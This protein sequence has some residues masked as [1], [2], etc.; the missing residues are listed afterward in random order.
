MATNQ[1]QLVARSNCAAGTTFY[2]CKSNS[3]S[4]CCSVDPCDL[5]SCPDATTAGS[6]TRPS[7]TF[8]VT[9]NTASPSAGSFD[10]TATETISSSSSTFSALPPTSVL[11]AASSSTLVTIIVSPSDSASSPTGGA[12]LPSYHENRNP[13]TIAVTASVAGLVVFASVAFCFVLSRHHRRARLRALVAQGHAGDEPTDKHSDAGGKENGG[14]I[15]S[16]FGGK[17]LRHQMA[18]FFTFKKADN[19]H[20]HDHPA[21]LVSGSQHRAHSGFWSPE[22]FKNEDTPNLDSKAIAPPAELHDSSLA[23]GQPAANELSA[24]AEVL[25]D[26]RPTTSAGAGKKTVNRDSVM[27]LWPTFQATSPADSSSMMGDGL[28]SLTPRT[29][30]PSPG[31]SWAEYKYMAEL[32]EDGC[33]DDEER[34]WIQKCC[35]ATPKDDDRSQQ[36][37]P[38]GGLMIELDPAKNDG[39]GHTETNTDAQ[40]DQPVGGL[41]LEHEPT[42]EKDD[43]HAKVNV[44]AHLGQQVSPVLDGDNFQDG[45]GGDGNISPRIAPTEE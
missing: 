10:L 26:S 30:K 45:T 11:T 12:A 29:P 37:Q 28:A 4:G 24:E 39:D 8:V 5:S 6:S 40:Q 23:R 18:E 22:P 16:A 20:V 42:K 19:A 21:S 17:H 13:T 14:G 2:I 43:S 3:F 25:K 34:E 31:M 44:N 32:R 9:V 15:F 1:I 38:G 7:G 27:T 35:D 36:G 33:D 41:M